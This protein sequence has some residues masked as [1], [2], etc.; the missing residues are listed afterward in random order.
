MEVRKKTGVIIKRE[1]QMRVRVSERERE[2]ERERREKERVRVTVL[3]EGK[4]NTKK[5]MV[6]HHHSNSSMKI[7]PSKILH[8]KMRLHLLFGR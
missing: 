7:I 5:Y 6:K 1:M 2:R 4:K 3:R 8:I